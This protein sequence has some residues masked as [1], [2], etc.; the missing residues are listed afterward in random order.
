MENNNHNGAHSMN[1]TIDIRELDPSIFG[2]PD[3]DIPFGSPEPEPAQNFL[4]N[5]YG[6]GKTFLCRAKGTSAES[7]AAKYGKAFRGWKFI[8]AK[9]TVDAL[10]A[11]DER[12]QGEFRAVE[13]TPTE[14]LVFNPGGW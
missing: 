12:N 13:W 8:T 3:I 6:E 9:R 4:F 10:A 5:L 2:G 7:V 14:K 11:S 1:P